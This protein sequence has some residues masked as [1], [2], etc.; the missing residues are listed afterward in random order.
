MGEELSREPSSINDNSVS[1]VT[2]KDLQ[3]EESSND[4][5]DAGKEMPNEDS[6]K[7]CRKN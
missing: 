6:S 5:S 3:N 7:T 1:T 2:G 4:M